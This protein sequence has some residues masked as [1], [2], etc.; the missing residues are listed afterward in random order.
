MIFIGRPE[1]NSALAG[2]AKAIG[3]DYAAADFRMDGKEHAS[4]TEAL[5]LAAA[6]PRDRKH[7]VL[8]LAGNSPLVDRAGGAIGRRAATVSL[9]CRQRRIQHPR[10]R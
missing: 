5:S 4:E 2:I 1:T 6:N 7:M 10:F 9:G 8:A 3:L